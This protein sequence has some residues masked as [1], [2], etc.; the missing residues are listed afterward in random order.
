M[1]IF[2]HPFCLFLLAACLTV[3][4]P[5]SLKAEETIPN[6]FMRPLMNWI[7]ESM[8][9]RVAQLPRAT[10]SLE[11]MLGEIGHPQRQSAL[12][13]A[14][15]IPGQ[16]II[17]DTFWDPGDQ[18]KV[19]FLLHELVHHAQYVTRRRYPCARA[20]EWEAYRLQNLW[21]IERGLPPAVDEEFIARMASCKK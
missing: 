9:V 19:S 18:R 7:G 14:M 10:V 13:R 2:H 20:K 15:Y 6:A 5:A 8:G 11:R 17:D 21:L 1:V 3:A 4:A 12:A 16:I